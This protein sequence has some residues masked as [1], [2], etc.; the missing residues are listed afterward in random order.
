MQANVRLS[1]SSQGYFKV[2]Y[3]DL[4]NSSPTKFSAKR[5]QKNGDKN[6]ENSQLHIGLKGVYIV[7]RQNPKRF[8]YLHY[9]PLRFLS[10]LRT[11]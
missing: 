3:G 5:E 4:E 6:E 10:L 8:G 7:S 1:A 11:P 2:V 9:N